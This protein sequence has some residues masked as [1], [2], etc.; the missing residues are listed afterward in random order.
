MSHSFIIDSQPLLLESQ[1]GKSQTTPA[2]IVSQAEGSNARST[3]DYN[4]NDTFGS[5][6][7]I[8]RQ[9]SEISEENTPN[10]VAKAGSVVT[11]S[12]TPVER[13]IDQRNNTPNPEG[14]YLDMST[15]DRNNCLQIEQTFEKEQHEMNKLKI[16]A[17]KESINAYVATY[18]YTGNTTVGLLEEVEESEET[19]PYIKVT[20][21]KTEDV[22]EEIKIPIGE[23]MSFDLVP[24]KSLIE[25]IFFEHRH[26]LITIV[27]KDGLKHTGYSPTV[28]KNGIYQVKFFEHNT[29][30]R[31]TIPLK[32]VFKFELTKA[33]CLRKKIQQNEDEIFIVRYECY[34]EMQMHR[35]WLVHYDTREIMLAGNEPEE[36]VSIPYDWIVEL[37]I[38]DR[39]IMQMTQAFTKEDD[40]PPPM[41]FSTEEEPTPMKTSTPTS[42]EEDDEPPPLESIE[43]TPS[44]KTNEYILLSKEEIERR[45][46]HL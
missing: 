27:T 9:S 19:Q 29:D 2:E 30:K 11:D 26:H 44:R 21:A 34:G 28:Y 35:G 46:E 42:I 7:T 39:R 15:P 36:S 25:H 13:E 16:N 14:K 8:S 41:E 1:D 4:N 18:A 24:H 12:H 38:E 6:L 37:E 5:T 45:D 43:E 3:P 33:D 20:V 17:L 40:E 31:R 23:I 22:T 10:K 32:G